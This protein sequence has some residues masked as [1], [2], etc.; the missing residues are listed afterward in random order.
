[1]KPQPT[2]APD[3]CKQQEVFWT[4]VEQ[5]VSGIAVDLIEM[6]LVEDQRLTPL[7]QIGKPARARRMLPMP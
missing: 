1:M 7:L 2:V 5:K 4:W 6:A 3:R